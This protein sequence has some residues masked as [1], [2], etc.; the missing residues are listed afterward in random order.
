MLVRLR[1]IETFLR[2]S[3][4]QF[5]FCTRRSWVHFSKHFVRIQHAV[6]ETCLKI[7]KLHLA[8]NL[9][10]FTFMLS[11]KGRY[12]HVCLDLLFQT[13]HVHSITTFLVFRWFRK[14]SRQNNRNRRLC[15]KQRMRYA[16]L[17]ILSD[18]GPTSFCVVARGSS[19]GFLMVG[20]S[21]H[22]TFLLSMPTG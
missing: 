3:F 20:L 19:S 16:F 14:D 9:A 21:V 22:T 2:N 12:E 15:A 11:N 17:S 8:P 4:R 7:R 18:S 1:R 6:L 13:L 10:L 5:F